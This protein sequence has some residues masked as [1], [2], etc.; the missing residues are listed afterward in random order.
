MWGGHVL[1]AEALICLASVVYH[2]ARGE[3]IKGQVAVAHVVLN[4]AGRDP[5]KICAEVQR[6]AQFSWQGLKT[7]PRAW[8]T[9]LWAAQFAAFSPDSTHGATQFDSNGRS[10]WKWKFVEVARVGGHVFY[11]GVGTSGR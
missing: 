11:R 10:Y 7:E 2:E 5:S 3:P 4:R 8:A 6:P 1:I 9:A